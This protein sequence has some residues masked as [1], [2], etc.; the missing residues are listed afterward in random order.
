MYQFERGSQKDR[1]VRHLMSGKKLTGLYATSSHPNWKPIMDYRKRISEL[2]AYGIPIE[3]AYLVSPA[4]KK[5]DK[6]KTY[7]ISQK[8]REKLR[9]P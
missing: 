4:T 8:N 9:K 6:Y 5:P 7:W 1:I 3:S 2:I